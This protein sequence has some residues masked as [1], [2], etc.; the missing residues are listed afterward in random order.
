MPCSAG[1]LRGVVR[2]LG[3]VAGPRS[4][5][6]AAPPMWTSR[7]VRS[8]ITHARCNERAPQGATEGAAC[9]ETGGNSAQFE[10]IDA[11]K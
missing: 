3:G 2:S 10:P 8:G 7:P 6:L 9:I 11:R 5:R 4:E 1:A